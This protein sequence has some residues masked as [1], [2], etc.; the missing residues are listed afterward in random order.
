MKTFAVLGSGGWGTA[1]AC[2]L[3]ARPGHV[4]RLWSRRP[5]NADELRACRE[6]RRQLPGVAIPDNVT[7]TADPREAVAD[8]DCWVTAVPCAYLRESLAPFRGLLPPGGPVVSVTKG[9]ERETFRRPSEILAD[10]LGAENVVAL[11]GPS[12]AEEVARGLPTSLVAAAVHA[13][14]ALAVQK[15]FGGP[16]LRIYTNLDLLGVELA[17]AL[18][19]VIAIAAGVSDG[20][21]FG[22]NAKSA[23]LSRGLVEMSRFGALFGADPGTFLGLAGVGDLV[24]TCFSK[25]GRNRRVG[26]ELAAGK[27]TLAEVLARP[28]VAEGVFTAKS[29]RDRVRGTA[30]EMPIACGV[31]DILYEGVTPRDA[32]KLLL[33]RAQRG[34]DTFLG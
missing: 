20:L 12:H 13:D 15:A 4:V 26:D 22:D 30:I 5:E 9:I 2:H 25:H 6:N 32:V 17:G 8:A 29:V 23:I 14:T 3:A 18:K 21:G 27:A 7:V 28:Q 11:S 16:R 34:E 10:V 19:N 24:T 1:L 31:H 33:A